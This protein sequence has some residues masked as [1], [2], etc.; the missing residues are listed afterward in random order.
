MA[1]CDRL[2]PYPHRCKV[3]RGVLLVMAMLLLPGCGG[4]WGY[5]WGEY[6]GSIERMYRHSETFSP[7]EDASTLQKELD[8]SVEKGRRIPPGK[9]AHL[10]MLYDL[11]GDRRAAIR[12]FES[13]KTLYP[14]SAKFMNFLVEKSR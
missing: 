1:D 14:E 9:W 3:P 2:M 13:E 5:D 12:C 4:S 6:P 10:G 11:T 7:A 8:R